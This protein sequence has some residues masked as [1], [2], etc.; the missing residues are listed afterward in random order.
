MDVIGYAHRLIQSVFE[1]II[2]DPQPFLDAL[3]QIPEPTSL[4]AEY[5]RPEK[6]EAVAA[7]LTLQS[8]V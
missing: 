5:N 1:E 4:S 6:E 7:R 2:H 3:K 8:R